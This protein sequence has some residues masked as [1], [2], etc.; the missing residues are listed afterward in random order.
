MLQLFQGESG[1]LLGCQ[2]Y[3]NKNN[4]HFSVSFNDG[5]IKRNDNLDEEQSNYEG[6]G[7]VVVFPLNLY[8]ETD[9][10]VKTL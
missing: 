8:H 2:I 4:K 3:N 5:D 6:Q 1:L 9:H 10:V 7:Y